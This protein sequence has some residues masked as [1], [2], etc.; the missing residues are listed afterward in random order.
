I[1]GVVATVDGG[2]GGDAPLTVERI[3][4]QAYKAAGRTLDDLPY[5]PEFDGIMAASRGQFPPL[6]NSD[7][8][9]KLHN[10]RRAGRLPRLGRAPG[11]KP[12][13]PVDDERLLTEL[14]QM[15]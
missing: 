15:T 12:A 6:T 1:R 7:A 10:I 8:F 2:A 4:C 14:I 9:N 13:V 3:L 5:T 11:T